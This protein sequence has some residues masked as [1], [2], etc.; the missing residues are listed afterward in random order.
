MRF[1]IRNCKQLGHKN[2]FMPHPIHSVRSTRLLQCSPRLLQRWSI[3]TSGSQIYTDLNTTGIHTLR[4]R[5]TQNTLYLS[6][7]TSATTFH[8]ENARKSLNTATIKPS[9]SYITF[10]AVG[11]LKI[12]EHF[13]FI[14][15]IL[16]LLARTFYIL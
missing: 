1:V 5:K 6:V 10:N 3:C 7:T 12:H 14:H 2:S 13:N 4:Q 8:I 16:S 11:G 15:K 9:V